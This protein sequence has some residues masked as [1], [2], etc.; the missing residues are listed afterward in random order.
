MSVRH[1]PSTHGPRPK[2][3]GLVRIAAVS[4]LVGALVG[5]IAIAALAVTRPPADDQQAP[6]GGST[7]TTV[8]ETATTGDGPASTATTLAA[9][10]PQQGLT[11]PAPADPRVGLGDPVPAPAP[12]GAEEMLACMDQYRVDHGFEDILQQYG[13]Y[14]RAMQDLSFAAQQ[15]CSTPDWSPTP[16]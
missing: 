11:P 2:S 13:M 6:V 9:E 8:A 1:L 15:A 5:G 14:S 16:G 12:D 10:P 4:A 3:E 7:A